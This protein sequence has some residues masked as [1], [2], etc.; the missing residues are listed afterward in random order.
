MRAANDIG[1]F[2]KTYVLFHAQVRIS[3]FVFR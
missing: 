1:I 3:A 2:I